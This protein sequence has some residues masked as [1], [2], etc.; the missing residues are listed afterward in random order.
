MKHKWRVTK[1]RDDMWRCARC[2]ALK[3]RVERT[4]MRAK[5]LYSLD[6]R[7]WTPVQPGCR[8]GD[9]DGEEGA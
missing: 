5:S 6:G 2:S 9:E 4:N 7:V 1:R 8:K 3:Q